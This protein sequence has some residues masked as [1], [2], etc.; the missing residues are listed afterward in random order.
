MYFTEH[1]IVYINGKWKKAT[2]TT[3]GMYGQTLH[4]GNGVFEGIRAYET[5]LGTQV[6]KAHAHYERLKY[7]CDVM[8]I[9]LQHSV[10]E[11][12]SLT[13]ELL[14]RNNFKD[15]YIRPLV[16]TG[17]DM[18]LNT[19]GETSLFLCAWEWGPYLGE[20]RLNVMT[21]TFQRPNPKSCIV[22]AKVS[23]HYVNSIL[24]VNEA[25]Q[26]GYDEALLTDMNGYI[27]EGP[28]ANFFY[29]KEGTLYTPPKGNIMPGITRATIMELAHDMEMPVKETYF[30]TEEVLGAD[31]AFFTGTA[32]EVIGLDS[33]DGVPFSK[34]FS[35]T[36]GARLR[37][38]YKSLVLNT[39]A[40]LIDVV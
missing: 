32:A 13:Y 29:E 25:K 37:A 9:E 26:K 35:E 2:E 7:S 33:L 3:L 5:P 20:K 30:K 27:A 28:G 10:E 8:G 11:L 40:H 12:V 6:F 14:D 36:M 34:P 4:Y 17:A 16:T 15:A 22:D 1:S 19:S 23:G 24:A 21:S 39:D 18:S 38:A 31:G